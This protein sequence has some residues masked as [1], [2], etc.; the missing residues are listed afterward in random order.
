MEENM[1]GIEALHW[2]AGQTWNTALDIGSGAGE[3]ALYL[4]DADPLRHVITL[5]SR[6]QGAMYNVPYLIY[7][8]AQQYD[9]I[10]CSHVLEHQV[11]PGCFLHKIYDDVVDGGPIAIT[12]PPLKH[13][14]VGGHVSL[15]NP[16]LLAYHLILAGFDLKEAEIWQYG[17]NISACFY[18]TPID[19]MPHLMNDSGDIERL[20]NYFPAT[21]PI[22]EGFHGSN[23][24]NG[25][26]DGSPYKAPT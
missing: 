2:F 19:D 14:I 1:F 25:N 22:H 5:D 6:N 16:G 13:E 7:A 4:T 9:A 17:Y 20:K 26:A 3:Q 15:W 24:V 8:P 11:D 10:W 18:K 12:V 23:I 21:W